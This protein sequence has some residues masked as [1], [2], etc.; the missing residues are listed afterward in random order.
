MSV[1]DSIKVKKNVFFDTSPLIYYIESHP[2]FG[3]IV[4]EIV[5]YINNNN[6]EVFTSVLTITEVLTKPVAMKRN[7]LVKDFIDFLS[8]KEN[9][10]MIEISSKIAE[11]AGYLKGKYSALKTIDSIQIAAAI[12]FDIDVFITNDIRLKNINEIEILILKDYL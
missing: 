6:I 3:P 9:F 8:N 12:F 5:G 7:D 2:D 10:N 1:I 11:S 4:K